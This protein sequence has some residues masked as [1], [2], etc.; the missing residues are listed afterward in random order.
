[1]ARVV[2]L[3]TNE[4]IGYFV[5]LYGQLE[6]RQTGCFFD[7]YRHPD[8]TLRADP[9]AGETHPTPWKISVAVE[10]PGQVDCTLLVTPEYLDFILGHPS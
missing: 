3:D 10:N 8:G 9:A 5:D 2:R 7:A 6:A 4:K 1:M